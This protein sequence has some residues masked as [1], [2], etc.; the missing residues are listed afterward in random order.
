MSDEIEVTDAMT[1]ENWKALIRLVE[2]KAVATENWASA[3]AQWERLATKVRAMAAAAPGREVTT[4]NSLS[5]IVE[6]ISD[7][8]YRRSDS[9][10][11][12]MQTFLLAFAAEIERRCKETK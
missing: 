5:R 7:V 8:F 6:Q 2:G 1:P 11:D 4:S 12:R 9:A 10:N 3:R